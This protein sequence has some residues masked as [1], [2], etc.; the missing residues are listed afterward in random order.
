MHVLFLSTRSPYPINGGHPQRTF[1][2]LQEAAR[3]HYVSFVTFIQH[4]EEWDG[5]DKIKEFCQEVYAFEAPS[6]SSKFAL[7]AGLVANTISSRPFVAQKYDTMAFRRTI[8]RVREDHGIDLLHLD[9]LPLVAYANEAPNK[10]KVLVHHNVEHVLL[11]RRADTEKGLARRFW[12]EQARRLK[13]YEAEAVRKVTRSIAVSDVDAEILTQ[14]APGCQVRTVPNG[15]N[16]E[17]F[18]PMDVPVDPLEILYVG[19]MTHHPN[20]DAVRY[21]CEKSWPIIRAAKPNAKFTIVGAHPPPD[22]KALEERYGGVTVVGQVPDIRPYVARAS[23]YVVPLR[24][25]GGTRLKILDAM[26]MGKAVVT[27]SIGCEGLE[28][29]DGRDIIIADTP[30]LFAGWVL[31]VMKNPEMQQAIGVSARATV[32]RLYTWKRLGELQEMVYQEAKAEIKARE[33]KY[34]YV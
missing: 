13:N 34:G 8:R 28:V 10:A 18:T 14:L 23:V 32:E 30:E 24:I 6:D 17:Y 22:L 7:G 27:T 19:A 9:M 1:H 3:R 5:L 20:V 33:P 4:P 12:L 11:Q 15:V 25:G 2:L 31:D 21:F 29:T 26:A 16:T